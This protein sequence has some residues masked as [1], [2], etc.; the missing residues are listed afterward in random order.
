VGSC[1]GRKEGK[2]KRKRIYYVKIR[3]E[4]EDN[5]SRS[6]RGMDT[7]PEVRELPSGDSLLRPRL[8]PISRVTF[9]VTLSRSCLVV[10]TYKSVGS[11]QGD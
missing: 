10:V 11:I 3:T 7:S 1:H 9:H 5:S 8:V 4:A 2:R 6:A